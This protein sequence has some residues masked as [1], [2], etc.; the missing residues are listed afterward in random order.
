MSHSQ[1]RTICFECHSR[2]GV[3][4]D[5]EDNRMVG[6]K[7]DKSHPFSKGFICPK[8]KACGELIYHPDR[9]TTPLVRIG[10]KGSGRFGKVS[11]DRALSIIADKMLQARE[12]CGAESVVLGHGT[13][14][15]LSPYLYRFASTFGSPNVM[16]PSNYSGGPIIMGSV[17]TCGFSMMEPDFSNSKNIV[18]WATNPDASMPGRFLYEIN[19]GLKA[20]AVLTVVDP[21]GTRLARKAHHWLQIRPGTD[22]A[23]ILGFLN[24]II[25]KGLY[26]KAF[27]EKWT[28]GFDQ[29]KEHVSQFNPERCAEITWVPADEI[30]RAA[31]TF[32]EHRPGAIFMGIGGAS[33]Q[34]DAFDMNRALAMLSA[35]TGN[36]DV[37]GGNLHAIPPT[38]DRSCYGREFNFLNNLPPSQVGKKIGGDRF[39]LLSLMGIPSPSETVWPV[40]LEQKPYPVKV[41]GLFANNAMCAFG[42]SP[43]IKKALTALDFLF[44][45]DYFHTPTTAMADV[46]LPAAHWTERDDMEDLAMRNYLFCQPKALDPIPECRDEKQILIDL[47]RKMGM[48][49]YWGS[50]REILDY[51]LEPCGMTFEEFKEKHVLEGPAEFC[52]HE[53]RNGFETPSRK[54]E[55]YSQFLKDMGIEPMPVFREPGEGPVTHPELLKEFPLVLTTGGRNIAFYHSAHRNIP[56][57]RRLSPDPELQIHPETAKNLQISDGEWVYVASPRG[58]VEAKATFFEHIHP[59]V[60]HLPHGYW[61]G[62]TDGWK[63]FNVNMITD[64]EPLCPVSAGAPMKSLLCRV[65]KMK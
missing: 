47:T 57:L 28:V 7:G 59:K 19:Q 62:E 37:R 45:V 3:L 13:T 12:G 6:I 30:V 1:V 5:V 43:L 63:R 18:L 49:G 34:N 56:S 42:N 58:R 54:V 11:W 22:T 61:Y 50:V 24:V 21:R 44:S 51:R 53:K 16:A 14:R 36:L 64:N 35:I 2:C 4:I 31:T 46:I 17:M 33:Q 8:G 39:P 26:D 25:S 48:E 20:G 9:I 27:V 40:I 55:L 15:G 23:L 38:G 65:E 41:L 60:V 29:L 52:K 10:E 32:V